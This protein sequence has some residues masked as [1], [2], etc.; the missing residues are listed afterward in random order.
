MIPSTTTEV[1]VHHECK[2]FKVKVNVDLYIAAPNADEADTYAMKYVR[3]ALSLNHQQGFKID[4]PT[5]IGTGLI[6]Q[7]RV[8]IYHPRE[9]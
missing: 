4:I 9:M 7:G 8:T 6:K 3:R 2:R 5:H 1:A